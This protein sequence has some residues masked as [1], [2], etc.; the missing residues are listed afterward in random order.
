M[1]RRLPFGWD[2]R[3]ATLEAQVKYS[4]ATG[5]MSMRETGNPVKVEVIE[6]RI[7]DVPEYVERFRR[8]CRGRHHAG[9]DRARDRRL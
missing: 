6:Q 5:A 3:N 8:R 7:R 2:G 1:P 9:Y 4:V